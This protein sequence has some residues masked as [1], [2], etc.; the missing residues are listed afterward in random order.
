MKKI[1]LFHNYNSCVGAGLCLIQMVDA[2]KNNYDII[3]V[4]PLMQG[5]LASIL[6][7]KGV[8]VI[9]LNNTPVA[10]AHYSGGSHLFFSK[11]H[12]LNVYRIIKNKCVISTLIVENK[13]DIVFVNS[14]TLFWIGKIAKENNV[15]TIAYIRETYKDTFFN[16]R[17]NYI[18]KCLNKYFDK[19]IFISNYDRIL[20]SSE[21]R[22]FYTITDKVDFKLFDQVNKHRIREEL[23]LPLNK[24]LILYV[25]GDNPIKGPLIAIKAVKN[26]KKDN[27]AL[28]YLQH[29][30][31]SN[32]KSLRLFLRRIIKKDISYEVERFIKKNHL[33]NK[34]LLR[35]KTNSV[36]KYFIASDLV[37]FPS[38]FKHQAR[39]IY[40]AG[41]ANKPI[42]ITDFENTHEFACEDN[43]FLV[44]VNDD[45]QLT[46]IIDYIIDNLDNENVVYRVKNN[47]N[48]SIKNHNLET[49]NRELVQCIEEVKK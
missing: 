33:E 26:C 31:P 41:Y 30:K 39:P 17:T 36:E 18:K 11:S 24:K 14:M 40:E 2:L 13:P 42:I 47:Y 12:L 20:T 25:G 49:F 22:N 29:N 27:L 34:V 1:M 48:N 6:K 8:N 16:V 38:I 32:K 5:D 43:S 15:E 35:E 23:K 28:V 37:V 3:V 46:N 10:Y 19:C 4:L 45:K 21:N 44:K 9:Q 7:E